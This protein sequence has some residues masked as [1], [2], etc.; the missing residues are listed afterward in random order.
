[1]NPSHGG[2]RLH[3]QCWS[4][5]LLLALAW[6]GRAENESAL[7]LVPF[8]KEV[9]IE[10][11]SFSLKRDFIFEASPSGEVVGQEL[12]AELQR[13]GLKP[14]PPNSA[15]SG[16]QLGHFLRWSTDPAPARETFQFRSGATEEDYVL[17]VRSNVVVIA[18][19]GPSG[20]F[21]G[22][23]TLAQLLRANRQG[24][25]LPGV[26]IR[27]WPSVRWRAFQDDLTRGPASTLTELEREA[28][29]GAF[30]KLNLFTYYM[31]HQFAFRKHPTI[32]PKDG[33]LTP[34]ELR[35]LVATAQPLHLNILGNQQSFGHF[36]AILAHPEYQELRETPY[37]LSPTHEGSYRLLDFFSFGARRLELYAQRELDRIAAAGAYREACRVPAKEAGPWIVQAETALRRVRDT[38]EELR[39]RFVVLWARENKP[40]ALDRVLQRFGLAVAKYNAVLDRLAYA[41]S[42]ARVGHFVP[43]P[44]DLGLELV[45]TGA[46]SP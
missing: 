22:G 41:R 28:G 33:S 43:T 37:L 15:P 16:A 25:S 19:P 9:R 32:G 24:E 11:G 14:L 46:E 30:F 6:L 4:W 10:P 18:A 21:Y 34:E 3:L 31:E 39:Q 26:S 1:M 12:S 38:H 35:A 17:L 5:T 36:T 40:Y 29:L 20:L 2:A 45:E 44:M 42:T 8:P 27:D 13:A 23:Q 7:R